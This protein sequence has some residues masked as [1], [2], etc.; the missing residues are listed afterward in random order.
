M[1]KVYIVASETWLRM[2]VEQEFDLLNETINEYLK[3]G[4]RIINIQKIKLDCGSW[5]FYIYI[6]G[7]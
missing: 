7:I 4:E 5:R 1:K 3:E 2:S 6:E